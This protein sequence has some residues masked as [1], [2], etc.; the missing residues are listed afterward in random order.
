MART[1]LVASV[2]GEKR[3]EDKREEREEE[4]WLHTGSCLSQ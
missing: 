4:E 1:L 3:E 2:M